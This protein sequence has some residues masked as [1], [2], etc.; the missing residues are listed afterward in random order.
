MR[1][2]LVDENE[3]ESPKLEG[4]VEAIE[5]FEL[6]TGFRLLLS[7]CKRSLEDGSRLI[8]VLNLT[9][10]P[11]TVNKNTNVGRKTDVSCK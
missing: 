10:K 2:R 11:V 7:A 8:K 1:F 4:L 3:E 9:D 5:G 6:K